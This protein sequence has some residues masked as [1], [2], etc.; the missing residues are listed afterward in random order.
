[1]KTIV[2]FHSA[3]FDGIFCREIA[4]RAL[5]DSATYIGWDYGDPIPE[6]PQE[7]NL[8]MMD[9]SIEPLMTHPRLTW[10]DHHQTAIAKYGNLPWYVPRQKYCIDGVAA[11]RL[12]WQ[13]FFQDQGFND[14][15]TRRQF[16]IRCV[17]EP[18][19]V[20]L[21]GEYDVWD[22]RD[23]SAETFQHGLRSCEIYF[24]RL[25]DD[26]DNAYVRQLLT[27][28]SSIQFA[29]A[30][31]Y[32]Q[33]IGEQGFNLHWEG[34]TWLACNSHELDIRS[35][36]FEAGIRLEHDA[37]LGFTW[38]GRQAAWRVS[39]YGV[40]RRPDLDLSVI[41]IKYGGGGHRQACGFRSPVLPFSLTP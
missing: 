33:V 29:R 23:P 12:A 36:L 10:I 6:V 26:Q 16:E 2:L 21:A 5:G 39:L 41:A 35:Q 14:F 4:K 15:P 8:I 20:R 40:P 11:C 17:S 38:N 13:W 9:L 34:L 19:A 22:K 30:R 24:P 32:E 27:A 25:F 18:W 1:M 7:A 37:L 28:G 31:E 3:D